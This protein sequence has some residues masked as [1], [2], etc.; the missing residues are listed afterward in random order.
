MEPEWLKGKSRPIRP[1]HYT[2]C[3]VFT[4]PIEEPMF[5]HALEE[6]PWGCMTHYIEQRDGVKRTTLCEGKTCVCKE[7][8]L[9]NRR[10][11]GYLP[12]VGATTGTLGIMAIT[13]KA[14]ESLAAI[15][16]KIGSI[17]NCRLKFFR[18]P[19]PKHVRR[20]ND[21]VHVAADG[22]GIGPKLTPAAFDVRPTVLLMYGYTPDQ[23]NALLGEPLFFD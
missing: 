13:R 4:V 6:E 15:R 12:V 22:P 5:C 20:K 16:V 19:R 17:K 10:W 7:N 1:K 3:H 18:V 23:V 21:E 14:D 8:P 9:V 2:P 11:V